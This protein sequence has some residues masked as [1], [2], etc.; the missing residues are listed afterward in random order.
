MTKIIKTTAFISTIMLLSGMIFKTQHWPGAEIIF[1]T[2]VAAGIFL[3]VIIISSFA[4]NLTSGIE[5]FNI[6]F[7]SLAIAIILL[8]YLFKIMHWPGAAKLV[9]AADLGIVLSI[10][11]FLYDGIREKDPVK[12]SLKIMAMFF[13]LFLLILIVLTT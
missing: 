2:G 3:T 8:A 11:L 7:S 10:L 6:I 13:L 9:W 1:M 5:K 4:G 12:S